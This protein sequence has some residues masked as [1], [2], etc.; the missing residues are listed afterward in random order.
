[1]AHK[2]A[3]ILMI[4]DADP[5]QHRAQIKTSKYEATIVL[6]MNC[7]QAVTVCRD[8]VHKEGVKSITLCPAFSNREVAKIEESVGE[9]IGV[10]AC[11]SDFMGTMTQ[12]KAIRE[13]G[14][15]A[16]SS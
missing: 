3:W 10:N 9:G 5:A 8:L 7:D 12:Y 6:V 16:K 14:W 4:P 11:R 1:M 2:G 15:F 13:E